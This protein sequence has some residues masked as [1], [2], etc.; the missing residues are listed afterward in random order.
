MAYTFVVTETGR[1]QQARPVTALTPH[2][3]GYNR[4]TLGIAAIGDFRTRS[5]DRNQWDATAQLCA[6]L[7][8][9]LLHI[10]RKNIKGHTERPGA[11]DDPG[12]VCPGSLWDMD[13]F[14]AH[15]ENRIKTVSLAELM[16]RGVIV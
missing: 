9:Y 16:I 15:V 3:K 1:I 12:K 10:D 14:R 2:S 11:S 5:P 4:T 6:F 13:K 8:I 7:C